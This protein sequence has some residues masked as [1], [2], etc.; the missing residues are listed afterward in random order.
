M[1]KLRRKK[2][3]KCTINVLIVGKLF[4]ANEGSHLYSYKNMQDDHWLSQTGW[5][6]CSSDLSPDLSIVGER[7]QIS[8]HTLGLLRRVPQN[9]LLSW[10]LLSAP[11]GVQERERRCRKWQ[12]LQARFDGSSTHP[13]PAGRENDSRCHYLLA[14]SFFFGKSWKTL[15]Y[16]EKPKRH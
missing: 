9:T 16:E 3:S 10:A 15:H 8:W 4:G 5:L 12:R 2:R 1:N 13:G 11:S 14:A 7:G 6:R